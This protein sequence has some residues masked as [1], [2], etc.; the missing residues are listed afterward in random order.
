MKLYSG[1]HE[2]ILKTFYPEHA[3]EYGPILSGLAS[4]MQEKIL[5]LS[6]DFDIHAREITQSRKELLSQGICRISLPLEYGGLGL[7]FAVYAMAMELAGMADASVALSIGIHNTVA[8]GVMA[9]GNREQKLELL[10]KMASGESLGAFS[11][12]EPT[13]GSDS[14]AMKTTAK[15]DGED[16]VLNGS[17]MFITNAGEADIYFV[18]ATTGKGPSTFLV[19]KDTPGLST[20]EDLPKLGMRGSRTSEVRFVECRIPAGNLVGEEG[21][22]FEHAKTLLNGSRIIMGSLC[23][24]IAEMAFTEALAYSKQRMAFGKSISEFELIREKIADMRIGINAG[25]LLC[26]Y[27]SRARDGGYDYSSVASQAK[28]FSS[29]MAVDACDSAIQI[30]GGYGYTGDDVHRHW[31][32]ARLLTIGEGTS[33]VLRMLIA[34]REL[35]NSV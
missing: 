17:K 8:E 20:G 5:P 9:F 24:G 33:E 21:K 16:Y 31:R 26:H 19:E 13:S 3:D 1:E 14:K 2:R 30:F 18:F 4:F 34:R 23:V 35:A 6:P 15:K 32:D 11:L 27:A 28:V 29:E 7:P 25:R 10:P 22:G 12:T